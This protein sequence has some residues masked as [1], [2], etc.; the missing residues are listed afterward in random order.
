M[1]DYFRALKTI[2][3]SPKAKVCDLRWM[4]TLPQGD[5]LAA[6]D[7]VLEQLGLFL[8]EETPLNQD[9]LDALTEVDER[10]S[11][12]L[13]VLTNQ[14]I[15]ATSLAFDIDER[16]WQ[17]VCHYY[18]RLGQA[19][20]RFL[21]QCK[22]DE[23]GLAHDLPQLVLN[24][25]D[26]KKNV[27]KWRYF[28]HLSMPPGGWLQVHQLYQLAEQEQC[29]EDI[30]WRYRN[31]GEASIVSIYL[32]MQMMGTLSASDMLKHEIEMVCSWLSSW[33]LMLVIGKDFDTSKHLFYVDLQEDKGGR[34]A[35]NL[36]PQNH[37]RYWDTDAIEARIAK[38]HVEMQH[39]KMPTDLMVGSGQRLSDCQPLL[40]YLLAEWSR[41]GYQ[42]QRRANSRS[43]ISKRSH[44][45]DGMDLVCQY[46][47]NAASARKKSRLPSV[48]SADPGKDYAS[49]LTLQLEGGGGVSMMAGEKWTFVNESKYGYGA[50]VPTGHNPWQRLGRLLA[51]YGDHDQRFPVLGVVRNIKQLPE[52]KAYVGIE[53]LSRRP[54]NVTL[55]SLDV[56]E[57][58]SAPE[59]T[60]I[61][62]AATLIKD[63]GL[64]FGALYI[65]KNEERSLPATLLVPA[66]QYVPNG[67]FELRSHPYLYKVRFGR[68]V[69]QRDD[70]VCVEA[71]MIENKV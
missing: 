66:L 49:A 6:Q 38:A 53:V 2:V 67:V 55:R 62:L 4:E 39:G 47:K 12:T 46:I 21:D 20:Q 60:D 14:Y 5:Y 7:V 26:C 29:A 64:P 59:N 43:E 56:A 3:G 50:V 42:R 24:V 34:R 22:T 28:R 54:I 48:A 27:L 13:T 40:E 18:E 57:E 11:P 17:S 51:F 63:G 70:W 9:T 44:V 58:K 32:Q 19:Y 37:F 71:R 10:S 52:G 45:V 1:V 31:Q 61:F 36:H 68:I 65:P 8:D 69:E 33:S 35:R 15:H 25:L 23:A 16:L 41:T 30:L